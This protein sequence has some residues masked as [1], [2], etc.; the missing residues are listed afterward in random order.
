MNLQTRKFRAVVLASIVMTTCLG[1]CAA[2][3]EPV[4]EYHP[5][6]LHG[7]V[8][9]FENRT[10]S[11]HY[12]PG[13]ETPGSIQISALNVLMATGDL[14]RGDVVVVERPSGGL[15]QV[16]AELLSVALQR[17]GLS[18]SLAISPDVPD[19]E[20]RLRI[21]HAV[22]RAP[23]CP[24]WTKPPGDDFDNTMPSNFG[25]ATATN[26]AAM[27]ANPRDLLAGSPMGPAVGAPALAAM[28]RYRFGKPTTGSN[29][30][31]GPASTATILVTPTSGTSK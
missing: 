27:V 3:R 7:V 25:C 19:G 14:G 8:V 13:A 6:V 20:L 12:A 9:T 18:A 1:G 21:E 17:E 23:G 31:A 16:R 22:A 2:T 24:D 10:L 28:H 15:A 4:A 30:D 29:T 11:V 5:V 26:L